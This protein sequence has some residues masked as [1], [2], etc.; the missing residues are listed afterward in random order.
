MSKVNKELQ[1][2]FNPA[3]GDGN[4]HIADKYVH[5]A[6]GG[7]GGENAPGDGFGYGSYVRFFVQGLYPYFCGSFLI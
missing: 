5:Q 4:C 6:H 1:D 2:N 3:H 7:K